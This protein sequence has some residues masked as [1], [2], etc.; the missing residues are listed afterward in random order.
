M[1]HNV[2]LYL[3]VDFYIRTGCSR[4][5]VHLSIWEDNMSSL[6]FGCVHEN[7]IQQKILFS[8]MC[9]ENEAHNMIC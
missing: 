1:S 5:L 8:S 2:T 3:M 4:I 7:K 6:H 9:F